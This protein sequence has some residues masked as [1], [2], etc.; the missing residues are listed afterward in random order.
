MCDEIL[1]AVR[2]LRGDAETGLASESGG[3]LCA[4]VARLEAALKDAADRLERTKKSFK[5]EQVRQV[6]ERLLQALADDRVTAGACGA[7]AEGR[8]SRDATF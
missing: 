7:A 4:R 5:S 2:R 6:R 8:P 1:A 3:A